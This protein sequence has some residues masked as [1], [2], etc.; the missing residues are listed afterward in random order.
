MAGDPGDPT[1]LVV[2]YGDKADGRLGKFKSATGSERFRIVYV[3]R[4]GRE[5]RLDD[6]MTRGRQARSHHYA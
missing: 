3:N 4:H 6:H 5:P 2:P 1:P